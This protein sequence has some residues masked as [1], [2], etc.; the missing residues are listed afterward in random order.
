MLN[1]THDQVSIFANFLQIH[2]SCRNFLDAV[3]DGVA[4]DG[5][6]ADAGD[7][8]DEFVFCSFLVV[9]SRHHTI[10]LTGANE[11]FV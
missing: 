5:F 7:H 10:A 3:V 11:T 6:E 8:G 9:A 1:A 4:F 2:F